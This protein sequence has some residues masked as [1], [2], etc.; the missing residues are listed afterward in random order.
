[1]FRLIAE[2]HL[3]DQRP[4]LRGG[5]PDHVTPLWVNPLPGAALGPGCE[6][7]PDEQDEPIGIPPSTAL[8][9][10]GLCARPESGDE[11]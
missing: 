11:V 3:I 6:H 1:M 5:A 2:H 7:G 4:Q 9:E 10:A 8:S